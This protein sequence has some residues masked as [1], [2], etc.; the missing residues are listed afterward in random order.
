MLLEGQRKFDIRVWVLVDADFN[1]YMHK[2]KTLIL[3][4]FQDDVL[5][6][7]TKLHDV[8]FINNDLHSNEFA[9]G[10]LLGLFFGN[11]Q[12]NHETKEG[13]LR[14]VQTQSKNYDQNI[15]AESTLSLD[16]IS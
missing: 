5:K 6:R 9:R 12:L 16:Q 11:G 15:K 13:T 4:D 7:T 1:V 2:E 3:K 14:Y 8:R 10:F